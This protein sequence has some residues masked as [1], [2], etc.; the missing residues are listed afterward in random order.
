MFTKMTY[1]SFC[2]IDKPFGILFT[3]AFCHMEHVGLPNIGRQATVMSV[4]G[5]DARGSDAHASRLHFL[6]PA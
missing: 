3:D 2:I 4:T 1:E 6:D 5:R